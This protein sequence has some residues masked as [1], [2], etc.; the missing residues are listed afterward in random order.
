[1]H[2]TPKKVK[3]KPEIRD[4][5][6][7]KEV[8]GAPGPHVLINSRPMMS[9]NAA[10]DGSADEQAVPESEAA[11]PQAAPVKRPVIAPLHPAEVAA[12]RKAREQAEAGARPT[13]ASAPQDETEDAPSAAADPTSASSE[14]VPA[15]ETPADAS[16]VTTEDEAISP[17]SGSQASAKQPSAETRK[18]VEAAARAAKRQEELD[19]Y[20][21]S[22]QFF[23]PINAAAQ[24][25]SIQISV[26]L[27]IV[28]LI[29]AFI[30][31]D[32]M[33]DSGLILLVQKIP[34]TH[35]F[36]GG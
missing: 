20:I 1:M 18:A 11:A 10:A 35:F 32:L 34:H 30:L 2:P 13:E 36:T 33:L 23:V 14:D 19:Q 27:T 9:Q 31:I 24:K 28:V 17:E 22:K 3:T 16:E 4:V 6:P 15:T 25:R 21:N 12:A 29:L 5:I 7:P 26:L 8:A